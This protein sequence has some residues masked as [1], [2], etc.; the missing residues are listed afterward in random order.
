M[1]E[2]DWIW[3]FYLLPLPLLAYF[4]LPASPKSSASLFMPLVKPDEFSTSIQTTKSSSKVILIGLIL[5]W[6][7]LI[8]SLA[9]P[10][11]IGEAIELPSTGRDLLLAVDISESMLEQ[12]MELGRKRVNRLVMVKAVLKEFISKR[13]GDRRGLVLFGDNAH[14]QAPLTLDLNTVSQLLRESE[15]GFAGRATALGDAIGLSIKK[16]KDTPA[17]NRILILLTDGRNTSGSVSPIQAA[18]LAQ[19][20]SLVVYTI[21][22]GSKR[23]RSSQ[24]IDEQTLKEISSITGGK[25]FRATN[26][27]DLLSIYDTID[28]LEAIDQEAEIF[29]PRQTLFHWPLALALVMFLLT[30]LT[31]RLSA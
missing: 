9:N 6:V 14:L 10:I 2:F 18:N 26:Q 19:Q 31:R 15:I 23:A 22:V 3:A 27:S 28:K 30:L 16:L 20:E 8:F 7:A 5:S 21:G 25:Y 12:D 1:I 29:R 11:R 24:S 17:D 13:Q 4:G